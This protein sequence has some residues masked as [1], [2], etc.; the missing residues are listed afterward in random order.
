MDHSMKRCRYWNC[1]QLLPISEF[2]LNRQSADGHVNICRRCQRAKRKQYVAM[3]P[4][5][6]ALNKRNYRQ[7]NP[8]ANAVNKLKRRRA[9]AAVDCVT[10]LQCEM[11]ENWQA[12]ACACCGRVVPLQIDHV[13]PKGPST[14]PN[15]QL[16]CGPCNVRKG[17]EKIKNYRSED[18]IQKLET[19]VNVV[20]KVCQ[21][22]SAADIGML[23]SKP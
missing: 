15:I 22:L 8:Y 1:M 19:F 3:N 21:P 6:N 7:R 11:L 20:G 5:Q 23:L 16:L 18:I 4:E 2:N 10:A 12:S 17:P 14:L 9:L 13:D